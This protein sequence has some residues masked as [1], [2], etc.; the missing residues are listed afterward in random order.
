[1]FSYW[2]TIRISRSGLIVYFMI[3]SKRE[4]SD[5]FFFDVKKKKKGGRKGSWVSRRGQYPST[6]VTA[7]SQPLV[8]WSKWGKHT[9]GLWSIPTV[10]LCYTAHH[11]TL[12]L[13]AS[14]IGPGAGNLSAV[15]TLGEK[16]NFC[17]YKSSRLKTLQAVGRGCR[18]HL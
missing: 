17:I 9:G 13:P 14:K 8:C 6:D 10:W 11:D 12:A 4:T 16:Q 2:T 5:L 18:Y 1:M 7:A 15:T 3:V